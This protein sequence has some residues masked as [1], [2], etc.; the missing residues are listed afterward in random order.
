LLQLKVFIKSNLNGY[1]LI[2]AT[3]VNGH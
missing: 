1:F 2:F 3:V